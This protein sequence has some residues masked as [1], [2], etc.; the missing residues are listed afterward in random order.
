MFKNL[1]T[2][3]TDKIKTFVHLHKVKLNMLELHPHDHSACLS[4]KD[5]N[6]VQAADHT[7]RM[8]WTMDACCSD[9][10]TLAVER[11]IQML[12]DLVL[13][14]H[15]AAA[16]YIELGGTYATF[17]LKQEQKKAILDTLANALDT[18]NT[19][20]EY[21]LFG[22]TDTYCYDLGRN[23]VCSSGTLIEKG[24]DHWMRRVDNMD[25]I[26][27]LVSKGSKLPNV[28]KISIFNT[29]TKRN[30]S[31][32]IFDLLEPHFIELS[33]SVNTAE[34]AS[35]NGIGNCFDNLRK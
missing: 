22:F 10:D 32:F 34:E 5:P 3:H 20:V 27:H 18:S 24:I 33:S 23:T 7:K 28:L 16:M 17:K 15:D 12:A 8:Q 9:P 19:T 25:D 11:E 1:A 6:N 30:G 31:L 21:V 29:S 35:T 4:I 14:G 26:W 2:V 13:Q